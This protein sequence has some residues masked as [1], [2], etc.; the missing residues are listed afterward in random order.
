MNVGIIAHNS[1]KALIEDFCIAIRIFW[2]SMR[3][4]QQG[5][6]DAELKRLQ[7]CVSTNS[8]R[9]AWEEINSLQK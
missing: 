6:R 7:I 5:L 9:E 1:K 8:F 3:F 4:M 2:Q